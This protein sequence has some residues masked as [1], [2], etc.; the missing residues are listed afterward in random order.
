LGT[1]FEVAWTGAGY[2]ARSTDSLHQEPSL[3]YYDDEFVQRRRISL[4]PG[5]YNIRL[6]ALPELIS[7]PP[8]AAFYQIEPTGSPGRWRPGLIGP[9]YFQR[10]APDGAL[11][12]EAVRVAFPG[13]VDLISAR[14]DPR[15]FVVYAGRDPAAYFAVVGAD[16]QS[17]AQGQNHQSVACPRS[18]CVEIVKVSA[19]LEVRSL[20]GDVGSFKVSDVHSIGNLAANGDRI[21][22]EGESW[23][24]G[25]H[26]HRYGAYKK[27]AIVD[28]AKRRLVRIDS[29]STITLWGWDGPLMAP[30][31]DGFAV[32]IQ[33]AGTL[34]TTHVIQCT[35]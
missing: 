32:A 12:G 30:T 16:G 22:I 15:A 27:F 17:L 11:R 6:V 19:G 7:A 33:S 4:A 13:D 8:I 14:G 25:P 35:Q 21:L 28:V 24:D 2:L 34:E 31:P 10:L 9:V 5:A 23:N 3:A 20:E 18:G 29:A 26:G 1:V